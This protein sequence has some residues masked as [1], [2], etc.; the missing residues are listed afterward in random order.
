M[1]TISKTTDCRNG[2]ER[3][4]LIIASILQRVDSDMEAGRNIDALP[5]DLAALMF[6]YADLRP[7]P[8]EEIEGEVSL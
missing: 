7:P 2:D 5:K 3:G 4:D 8:D 6:A 1:A